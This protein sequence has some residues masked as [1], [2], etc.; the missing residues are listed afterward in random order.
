MA[1]SASFTALLLRVQP[2]RDHDVVCSA[3]TSEGLP[4]DCLARGGRK[5]SRRYG[6]VL[7]AFQVGHCVLRRGRGRLPTLESFELHACDL[8][9]GASYAHLCAASSVLE[10]AQRSA[11]PDQRDP[12]L[13][14]W[15]RRSL[16]LVAQASVDLL[17]WTMLVCDLRL[18]HLLGC[19]PQLECCGRCGGSTLNGA[20]WLASDEELECSDCRPEAQLRG[21][22]LSVIQQVCHAGEFPVNGRISR[23]EGTFLRSR[24][25]DLF[26]AMWGKALTT[27]QTE[28]F[29]PSTC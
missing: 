28:P 19:L 5:N 1:P 20:S 21:R 18:L 2:L 15:T 29:F 22:T 24:V 7:A 4:V 23:R 16:S 17:Q 10:L 25:D 26:L 11:Q 14:H 8:P 3:L 13:F 27:R 6:G 12:D 9:V